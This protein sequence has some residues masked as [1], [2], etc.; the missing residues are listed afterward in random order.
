MTETYETI[1]ELLPALR[2]RQIPASQEEVESELEQLGLREP[3]GPE[4]LAEL[5]THLGPQHRVNQRVIKT[6]KVLSS[7]KWRD[8]VG[9]VR[10]ALGLPYTGLSQE[11]AIELHQGLLDTL[12]GGQAKEV[13]ID[14]PEQQIRELVPDYWHRVF[15]QTRPLCRFLGIDPSRLDDLIEEYGKHPADTLLG[16]SKLL[17]PACVF[18]VDGHELQDEPGQTDH[19]IGHVLW[20]HPLDP[21]FME[22]KPSMSCE[23]LRLAAGG[24]R[25]LSHIFNETG[26]TPSE[27]KELQR[28]MRG[29]KRMWRDG[30]LLSVVDED[31][32]QKLTWEQWWEKWNRQFPDYSYLTVG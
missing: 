26:A 2:R 12:L 8:A 11:Q 20:G 31:Q 17:D 28:K 27:L 5:V 3:F 19:L 14:R 23:W 24:G 4:D 15:K 7:K 1:L 25:F 22:S 29:I 13:R 30:L 6:K 21:E 16:I 32:W 18:I 9:G 10:L